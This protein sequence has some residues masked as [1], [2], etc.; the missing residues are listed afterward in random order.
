[1]QIEVPTNI[2]KPVIN[3][4][5]ADDVNTSDE[6]DNNI[7]NNSVHDFSCQI[8][9]QILKKNIGTQTE[10]QKT[11]IINNNYNKNE[12]LEIISYIYCVTMIIFTFIMSYVNI[13]HV[14]ISITIINL[15]FIC[16]S[17][18][19]NIDDKVGA[20]MKNI[21]KKHVGN[22]H[23]LKLKMESFVKKME[24]F[25][26][27]MEPFIKKMHDK[28]HY[29]FCFMFASLCTYTVYLSITID[30]KK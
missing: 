2:K 6:D 23:M 16:Y 21:Y 20:F 14:R 22:I 11:R 3:C 15:V 28:S 5:W 18:K 4:R 25:V 19:Y 12:H 17:Y 27:K 10:M 9:I 8:D 26:K 30:K 29:L 7:N 1:M 24:S 13:V